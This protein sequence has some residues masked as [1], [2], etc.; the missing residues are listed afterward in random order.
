MVAK[1]RSN[2]SKISPSNGDDLS[3]DLNLPVFAEPLIDFWPMKMIWEDAMRIFAA[4]R[5][6][7]MRHFDSPDKRLRDKN[8]EPFRLT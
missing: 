5:E 4:T 3:C 7:Y 2:E 8:P 1:M 6:H